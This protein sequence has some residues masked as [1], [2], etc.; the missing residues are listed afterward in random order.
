MQNIVI[1]KPYRFVP[2]RFSPFWARI[3]Q[4]YLP[5]YLRK[6]FGITSWECVGAHRLRA[7]LH[8]GAGVLLASNHSRPSDPT[9]LGLPA[10]K[11]AGPFH[12][13]AS[14]HLS[15]QSRV[16]SFRLP[17]IGGFSVYHDD[18]DASRPNTPLAFGFAVAR[19]RHGGHHVGRNGHCSS[20][21]STLNLGCPDRHLYRILGCGC[22]Q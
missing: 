19:G 11:I 13:M 1:A 14:W 5:T 22:S 7:S 10:R 4:W 20:A 3:I 6:N 17:R 12:A 2:P 16:L 15:I 18:L 8:A 21:A 9:V